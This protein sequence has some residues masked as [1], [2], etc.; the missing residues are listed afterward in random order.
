MLRSLI[1]LFT[2][3][4][5]AVSPVANGDPMPLPQ[6]ASP[7]PTRVQL[8]YEFRRDSRGF[9]AGFAD[10]PAG[11][12][13]F[14]ELEADHRRLPK[15]L[16][17]NRRA[18]FI[19]GNN[20]SDDL[21]MFVKTKIAGLRPGG[22]Y[23]IRFVAEFASNAPNGSFGIGGSPASSVYLKAGASRV[24][25]KPINNDGFMEMNVDKGVQ[26]QPGESA[27]VLGDVGVDTTY[28]RDGSPRYAFKT[29]SS[30]PGQSITLEADENGELWIFFGTDSGFEG[31]TAIFFTKFVVKLRDVASIGTNQA[32]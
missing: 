15:Y 20:H 31:T 2:V 9:A 7:E 4:L 32:D 14:Y 22:A 28:R 11:E 1:C 27:V 25:P 16:S 13:A 12:E 5:S 29:L 3:A 23:R 18:L 24:E 10:Y 17:E 8:H 26:S 19:S 21:F 30:K 6:A